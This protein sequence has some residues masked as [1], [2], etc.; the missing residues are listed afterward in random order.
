MQRLAP[1]IITVILG[2]L[3]TVACQMG[4]FTIDLMIYVLLIKM[5][6]E[7]C[8]AHTQAVGTCDL[9]VRFLV[10]PVDEDVL[11]RDEGDGKEFIFGRKGTTTGQ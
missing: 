8:T 9:L 4:L 6:Q 7:R 3:L 1:I 10:V 2:L 11:E 5:L